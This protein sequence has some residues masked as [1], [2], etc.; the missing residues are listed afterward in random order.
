M[1]CIHA[2]GSSKNGQIAAKLVWSYF[3]KNVDDTYNLT[4]KDI[5]DVDIYQV[6]HVL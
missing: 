2:A 5:E 4:L 3:V 6:W 1:K